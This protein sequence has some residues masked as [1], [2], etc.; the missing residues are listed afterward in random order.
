MTL[1]GSF[2][3]AHG[4]TEKSA[5]TPSPGGVA[6]LPW[7]ANFRSRLSTTSSQ[8]TSRGNRSVGL[9]VVL[10]LRPQ[11]FVDRFRKLRAFVDVRLRPVIAFG[12]FGRLRN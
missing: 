7:Q 5:V 3:L 4:I 1:N 12:F 11:W 9:R 8:P 10:Q 2:H 6:N